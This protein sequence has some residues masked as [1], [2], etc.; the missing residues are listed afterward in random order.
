VIVTFTNE[1]RTFALDN[2][3]AKAR[4][5]CRPKHA[6]SSAPA[7]FPRNERTMRPDD[8]FARW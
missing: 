8:A 2:F 3:K 4:F 7:H 6:A 1:E 5:Q